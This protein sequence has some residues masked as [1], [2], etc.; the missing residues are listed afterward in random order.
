MACP[1]V[2]AETLNLVSSRSIVFIRLTF[3]ETRH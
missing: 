1:A 2:I 3:K